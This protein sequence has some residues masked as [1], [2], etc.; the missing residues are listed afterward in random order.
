[1]LFKKIGI[2]RDLG[3]EIEIASGLTPQDRVIT[4]PMDGIA[5]GD[6]VHVL[7]K[8]DAKPPAAPQP[9]EAKN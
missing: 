7:E 6:E 1:M 8:P 4:T 2:L 3:S 9:G 5:D